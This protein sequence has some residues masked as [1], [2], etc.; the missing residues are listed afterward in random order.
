MTHDAP[1]LTLPEELILLALDPDR[2]RPACK[3]RDLAYGTAGAVLAELEIQG[4]IREERGRIQVVNPLDPADPLL[5]VLLRTLDPPAKGR[6]S[7]IRARRWVGEHDRYVQEKYLD[8]LVERSVLS[9]ETRRFLGVFPY[10]RHFPGVPDLARGVL[11]RFAAA[12]AAGYPD[13]RDRVLAALVSA[14]GLAGELTRLGRTGRTVMKVMRRSE[15]TA[16][17]VRHNV[18][19]HESGDG[20]SGDSGGG[21]GGGCGGGGGD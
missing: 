10:H 3:A 13:H 19:Q 7:G 11:D 14:I 17:A 18:K 1:A 20:W 12:E 8:A 15:W 4:R 9:R 6:R 5:A 16:E 2:G 21:D